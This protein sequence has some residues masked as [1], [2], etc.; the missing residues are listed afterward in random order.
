MTKQ[1]QDALLHIVNAINDG[2][3]ISNYEEIYTYLE[4]IVTTD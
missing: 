1:T 3:I 4:G 2:S